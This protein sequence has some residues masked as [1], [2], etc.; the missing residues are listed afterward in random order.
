MI[1]RLPIGL[2]NS[3]CYLL[4]DPATKIG[5][6]IDPGGENLQPLLAEIGRHEMQISYILNTHGHF[7]HVAANAALCAAF[8]AAQLGLHPDDQVLLQA[9][10]GADWFA[11]SYPPSPLPGLALIDGATLAVGCLQLQVLHTP[12]HTPGSVCLYCAQERALFS[13]DTLFPGSIGRTDL[14]GGNARQ[15]TASL[16]RLLALPDDTIVYPGHGAETTLA[17]ERRHNPWL[18]RLH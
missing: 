14:P 13:G 16:Q 9:G 7:D 12:G 11:L 4:H 15:L 5:V 10:G 17:A 8:P 18:R 6:V 1:V 2:V 3:N